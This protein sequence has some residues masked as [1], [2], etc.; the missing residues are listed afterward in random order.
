MNS[1]EP[2][3]HPQREMRYVGKIPACIFFVCEKIKAEL[4]IES[5]LVEEQRAVPTGHYSK[6]FEQVA[7][8]L[9][10]SDAT[11]REVSFMT[12]VSVDSVR[13]YA[14]WLRRS[15][16]PFKRRNCWTGYRTANPTRFRP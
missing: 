9:A 10:F 2:Y 4:G 15:G 7:R 16:I 11:Y 14:K 3:R 5:P 1:F 13:T 8:F 6:V 12:G